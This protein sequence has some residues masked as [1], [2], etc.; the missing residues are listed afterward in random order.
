MEFDVFG[1]KS[2]KVVVAGHFKGTKLEKGY[3]VYA[4]LNAKS[5][6]FDLEFDASET[7]VVSMEELSYDYKVKYHLDKTKSDSEL[8]AKLS[9]KEAELLLK[10]FNKEL[11][12]VDSKLQLSK[13][14][15]VVDTT[16]S[17]YGMPPSV[18]HFELKDF[19]TMKYTAARKATPNNKLQISSGLVFGQIADFRA[20]VIK[21]NAKNDLIHASVK[22]D[23]ANFMK[24]DFG[25]NVENIQKMVLVSFFKI[26]V[27]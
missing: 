26:R 7:I 16:M 24:P 17:A 2:H 19:N 6:G 18:H 12:Q 5:K 13:Q 4:D 20:E 10:M 25:I 8:K 1:K 11:L 22:L 15:Q 21:G 27:F 3:K 14:N 9:Q 23:D